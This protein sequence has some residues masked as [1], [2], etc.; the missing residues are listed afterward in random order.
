M[1][2]IRM[3]LIT[4]AL[5]ICS[6]MTV[7]AEEDHFTESALKFNVIT[8]D[9]D[10]QPVMLFSRMSIDDYLA[11]QCANHVKYIDISQYNITV[12]ELSGVLSSHYEYMITSGYISFKP[13]E[14]SPDESNPIVEILAPN[15]IFS[16]PEED[17]IGRKFIEDSVKQYADYARAC[18]DDPVEQLLLVHD[19]ILSTCTY[20]FEYNPI[21]YC[22]Y[23]LF[24]NNVTV[25]QG[26]AEAIY[27]IAKELGIDAGF[28]NYKIKQDDGSF[29][30]HI[31]NYIKIDD[32]WYQ[33]DATWNE[34]TYQYTDDDGN[35]YYDEYPN[36]GHA[37]FL[38]TDD[39]VAE[40]HYGK[41]AW[42]TSL[43]EQ[44]DCNSEKY[45]KDHL[46]NIYHRTNIKFSNG[47]FWT[48]LDV[49]SPYNS[50]IFT[51]GDSL[52]TG[53]IINSVVRNEDTQ[54]F[55]YHYF[56]EPIEKF[57]IIVAQKEA[58][59]LEDATIY[60][61]APSSGSYARYGLSATPI[62]KT[63]IAQEEGLEM[64]FWN[65]DNL[66]PL[67]TKVQLN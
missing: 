16:S 63:D 66:E 56:L 22:A 1:S 10:V 20:D 11:I 33:L 40:E 26:Y 5:I 51:S 36:V 44:P 39:V 6:S 59:I 2:K 38:V 17:E 54:F 18:T 21:S 3:L 47:K 27:M 53:K 43:E 30:G 13:K 8:E 58:N 45:M 48:T 62:P 31:W 49:Q 15:Y 23:G 60:T 67:S 19:K 50:I 4:M 14:N 12:K 61:K 57:N 52:Y 24:K 65:M 28:C 41:D 34:P 7:F 46:F 9:I 29:E 25:C 64:Y 35:V 42:A 55:V 32:Q 37:Y